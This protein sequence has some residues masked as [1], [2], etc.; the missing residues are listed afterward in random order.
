MATVNQSHVKSGFDV[1]ALM[2]ERYLQVLFQTAFDAGLIPS[3]TAFSDTRVLI[4]MLPQNARLYEPTL[5]SQG[6]PR[7]EDSDSFQTTILFGH[8]LGARLKVR[9]MIGTETIAPVPFDLFLQVDLSKEFEEGALTKVGVAIHIVDLESPALA[10]I[11]SQFGLTKDD[12]L[13]RLQGFVDRT[14]DVGGASKFKR[15]E[16]LTI[17]WHEGD[18]DHPP[19]LGLYVNVFMRNGDEDDQFLPVRGDLGEALNFLPSGEDMAMASRPGMYKDMAKDVF[20]RT[21]VPTESGGFEH[22]FRK[23]LLNPNSTR[24]GD[25]GSVHVGQIPPSTTAGPPVPQNGLRITVKG[26]IIDPTD[27]TNTDLTYIIDIRP[28]IDDDGL[29]VWDTDFTADVDAVFE[30]ITLWTATLLGILFGPGAALAFL[31]VVFVAELGVGIGISLYKEGSVAE[32][33]DA[34]LADVIQDRL[35]IK[36]RRWD[37]FY[38]TLHQVVTK[39]SQAEFNSAGFLMCGKAFVGRQLVPPDNSIIRDETRDASGAITGLRYRIADFET[40]KADSE[41]LAP[42]TSRRDFIPADEAEPDLWTLTLD[43]F[44]QRKD[45][46]EG[47]LVITKIPY[48]QAAVYIRGHQI[49]GILC[50]SETE[51]K[52]I[53]DVLREEARQRGRDRILAEDLG[54]ITEEV[55]EDLSAGG[56]TPTQEEIDAEVEKRVE[57][58]LKRV[59]D[60]YRSPEPLSMAFSGTLQPHLRFDVAP[61]ELVMLQQKEVVLIDGAVRVVKGRR[62]TTHVRDKPDMEPGPEGDEDNLL[63]RPRYTPTAAGPVFR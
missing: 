6:E 20:S 26:E 10:F 21:A 32:K 23:A 50:I 52:E 42:G 37:P 34:A 60:R 39:P 44:Q 40:V 57:K 59:M 55:I 28:R 2:G 43:A 3:E 48:F 38:A 11:E 19:A 17:A 5:D 12:V 58:E 62:V 9:L 51:I 63:N 25:L 24:L 46:P 61:E 56:A 7:L 31:G 33:A 8:P 49:D 30:F 1:E 54:T 13:A 18:D 14:L 45:D 27:L 4:A 29:L 22:A 35:T 16:D 41:L 15:V 53:Q 47:P 36:T